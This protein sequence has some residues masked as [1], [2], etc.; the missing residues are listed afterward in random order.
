MGSFFQSLIKNPL[1]RAQILAQ[2]RN[3]LGDPISA[4][5]LG[6]TANLHQNMGDY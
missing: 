2:V 5:A 1:V 3:V 4:L 6:C